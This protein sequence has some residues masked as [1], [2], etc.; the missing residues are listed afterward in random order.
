MFSATQESKDTGF[1]LC[2]LL[3]KW[4]RMGRPT[5][6]VTNVLLLYL[7]KNSFRDTDQKIRV[8]V[9]RFNTLLKTSS[10]SNKSGEKGTES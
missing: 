8:A 3:Q 6:P 2:S 5:G 9:C 4:E 1:L 7:E 10:L